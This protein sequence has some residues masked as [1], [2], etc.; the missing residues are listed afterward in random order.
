MLLSLPRV[1]ERAAQCRFARGAAAASYEH[2]RGSPFHLEREAKLI[3]VTRDWQKQ[4]HGPAD[5]SADRGRW[6][7]HLALEPGEKEA[8]ARVAPLVA[9]AEHFEIHTELLDGG[10]EGDVLLAL[11]VFAATK[12]EAVEQAQ[13]LLSNIR[14]EAHLAPAPSIVLGFI[15][16]WWH[17]T[18]RAEH[19]AR[20]AHE[21]HAQGRHELTV[22]RIQTQ[23]PE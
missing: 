23:I 10:I 5:G 18:S 16:P 1:S 14:R 22:I 11:R 3:R 15:S 2:R 8:I 19:I 12:Q 21:L 9:P 7:V 17:R 13:Y 6:Q 4:E 20:E